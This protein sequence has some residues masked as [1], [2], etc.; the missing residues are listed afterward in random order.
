MINIKERLKVLQ[1]KFYSKIVK[2][3]VDI[4]INDFFDIINDDN[5]DVKYLMIKN[6]ELRYS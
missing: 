6:N 5:L 2:Y 3:L 4:S 1:K